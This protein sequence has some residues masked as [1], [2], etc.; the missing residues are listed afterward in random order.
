MMKALK[1]MNAKGVTLLELLI[2]LVIFGFAI[3]GVYRIFVLQSRAYTVQD[4]VVEIQ[5]GIRSAM[6]V[7]LRDLRMAGYDSDSP[8][9]KVAVAIPI[10]NGDGS[11]ANPIIVEFEYDDT[12]RHSAAYWVEG[13]PLIL[14]RQLTKTKD[15][16]SSTTETQDLLENVEAF[17]LSY[18]IDTNGDGGVDNWTP[19]GVGGVKVVAVRVILTGKP[20]Q[21][22]PDVKNWINPRTLNS[23]ISLRNQ[24][25]SK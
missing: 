7:L 6:E 22:K 2:A 18:G 20:D 21:T 3:G 25:F 17:N 14:K 19:G 16:G 24:S 13:A 9:S 10:L 12:T 5:Q 11:K 4:Q 15:D 8:S 23:T 1:R